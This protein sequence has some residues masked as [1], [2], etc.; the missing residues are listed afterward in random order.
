[1]ALCALIAG[2][3]GYWLANARVAGFDI[4]GEFGDR[5]PFER[6]GRCFA[7]LW[8]H[9]ASYLSGF[10]V[11]LWSSFGPIVFAVAC[12]S[13]PPNERLTLPARVD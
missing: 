7:D 2:V 1:M 13:E 9:N 12:L 5:V 11:A 6:H 3:A 4:Y 8:A 10:V